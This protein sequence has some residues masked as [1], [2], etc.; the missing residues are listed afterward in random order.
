MSNRLV[1]IIFAGGF[2]IL[3]FTLFFF[4]IIKGNFFNSLSKKNC[5]RIIPLDS[6]R[7]EI[8]DRNGKII[9]ENKSSF[10]LSIVLQETDKDKALNQVSKILGEDKDIL[11]KEF[12]KNYAAPFIPAVIKKHI[13]RNEIIKIEENKLDLPGVIIEKNYT[14]Y[15]PFSSLCSHVLGY[16]SKIDKTRLQLLKPY[17][18]NPTD[19][20]GF[21]GIEEKY[22]YFLR[23]A[24]GGMQIEVDHRGRLVS[25]LGVRKPKDGASLYLT[26][27]A[28]IQRIVENSLIGKKGAV[29]IMSSK[30]GEILALASSP[31]FNPGWFISQNKDDRDRIKMLLKSKSSPLLNR[32]ISGVFPPGSI[33]KPV[34]SM[35]GLE[36][37]KINLTKKFDCKGFMKV[38]ARNFGCWSIHGLQ[39]M[40]EAIEHS[41]DV[42]F[43]NLGLILGPNLI[44]EYAQKFNLGEHTGIDLPNENKGLVPSPFWKRVKKF[45]GWFDGDTAN[46]SI[47][48]GDL[49]TTPIQMAVM[50]NVFA[51]NGLLVK[52]YIV[53]QIGDVKKSPVIKKLTFKNNNNLQIVKEGLFGV[54][55]RSDGTAHNLYMQDLSIA[56]KTGTAQVAGKESHGWFVG[57]LPADN[58][59]ISICVFLENGGSGAASSYLTKKI[60]EDL[61]KESLI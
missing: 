12:K 32:A 7:G 19:L 56:G 50:I 57:Y 3:I 34:V 33:F 5:I 31:N 27:D 18:Y 46:F 39:N 49:L 35:A 23:E 9:V 26:I 30:T 47:G 54:V 59:K 11:E 2:I 52:P 45:R 60:I 55:D 42:Y 58:P 61:Q 28:A 36:T 22:D 37:K 43:Y 41:C 21:S 4:Q 1:K 24:K 17:G 29:V 8:F 16:L 13:S 53:K 48:Q 10:D 38:G 20:V 6:M 14:R 25:I 44:A 51:T 40:I 15:Y